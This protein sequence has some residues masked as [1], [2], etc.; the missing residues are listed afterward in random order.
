MRLNHHSLSDLLDIK[1]H[2]TYS[3][4]FVE[5]VPINSHQKSA[6]LQGN[7]ETTST[8]AFYNVVYHKE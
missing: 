5:F 3:D 4:S 7:D 8:F 2:V 1:P 6:H